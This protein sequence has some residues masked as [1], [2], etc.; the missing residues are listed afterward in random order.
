MPRLPSFALLLVVR[1]REIAPRDDRGMVRAITC[2][3][4]RILIPVSFAITSVVAV[5]LVGVMGN[6][7]EVEGFLSEQESDP[8]GQRPL[9]FC[10]GEAG[11]VPL[12]R[13]VFDLLVLVPLVPSTDGSLRRCLVSAT[14]V[15]RRRDQ[16]PHQGEVAQ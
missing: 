16:H 11:V 1:W 2:N 13:S 12:R 5:V 15:R 9:S 14:V 6:P 3:G 10:F 7:E 8:I 4:S